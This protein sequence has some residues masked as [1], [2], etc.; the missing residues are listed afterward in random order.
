MMLSLF[1]GLTVGYLLYQLLLLVDEMSLYQILFGGINET[2]ANPSC[3][4]NQTEPELLL[5][6]RSDFRSFISVKSSQILSRISI[7]F[8]VY[9]ACSL[10]SQLFLVVTSVKFLSKFRVGFLSEL[11]SKP[12]SWYDLHSSSELSFYL[13]E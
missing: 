6:N 11:F 5:M 10:A 8:M 7:V 9:V 2:S 3:E 1:S 4:W 13:T 12:L